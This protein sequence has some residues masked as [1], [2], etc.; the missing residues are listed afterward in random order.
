M[1]QD[2]IRIRLQPDQQKV[3]EA[4]TG[5]L[6]DELAYP[7]PGGELSVR[8]PDL[9]PDD[10]LN[11]ARA[12]AIVTAYENDRVR[13]LEAL[14]EEQAA[15]DAENDE[16]IAQITDA[17]RQAAEE[18]ERMLW[19]ADPKNKKAIKAMKAEAAPK[20]KPTKPKKKAKKRPKKSDR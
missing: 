19:E 13:S 18:K 4:E 3:V 17:Q 14:D 5:V 9:P 1:A 11:W 7:D 8:F 6:L 10:V 16:A 15:L 2:V 12:Q 20:K